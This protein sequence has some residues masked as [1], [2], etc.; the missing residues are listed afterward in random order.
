MLDMNRIRV[1]AAGLREAVK[2]RGLD[3]PVERLLETDRVRREL[4]TRVEAARKSRNECSDAAGNCLRKG[5]KNEAEFYK[6]KG[7]LLNQEVTELELKLSAANAEYSGVLL[8]APN[9][10]SPDTP[11]GTSDVNNVPL[12]SC[13]EVPEMAEWT[14]D[15]LELGKL[16]SMI[17]AAGGVKIAGSRGYILRGEGAMLHRAVQQMAMDFLTGRG[18][19]PVEVP[20]AVKEHAMMQAGFFPQGRDQTYSVN[21][22]EFHLAGTAEVPLVAYLSGEILDVT[23]PVKLAAASACFR[24]EA[25]S[26]GRDV[27]GLYRVHQFAKVEQVVVCKDD[28]TT[29][30]ALLNEITGNAEQILQMLELPYRV[31]AVCAGDMGHKAYKQYDIETWMPSRQAYGETHSSS[32]LLDYQARRANIRFRDGEGRPRYCYTLNNTAVATPR[33]LIPLLEHH[34]KEDGSICIP[35]ALQPYMHGRKELKPEAVR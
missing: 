18:F 28:I 13:G 6:E 32:L 3:F 34:Q 12:R 22:G 16:H 20:V 11:P 9:L 35:Q 15:H 4:Q 21:D 1:D 17:D 8:L 29:A 30:E 2:A 26:A 5:L 23:H 14:K 31:V 27:R 33:I 10:V 7:R 25:G 24:S 19:E